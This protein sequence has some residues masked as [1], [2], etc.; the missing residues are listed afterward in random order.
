VGL[1]GTKRTLD[2]SKIQAQ[3]AAIA[4]VRSREPRTDEN[5]F[6]E[7]M[8]AL[9]IAPGG[10]V[11]VGGEPFFPVGLYSS[12]F[13]AKW[14][15]S[16][17][18]IAAAGFNVV[19][20]E[21]DVE[22]LDAAHLHGMKAIVYLGRLLDVSS[23]PERR[24]KSIERI[25]RP[26]A[27]HPALIAFESINEPSWTYAD[28]TANRVD[29][30]GLYEGHRYLKSLAP[31]RAILV[32]H[33]PHQL[34]TTLRHYSRGATAL[35]TAYYPIIPKNLGA[36]YGRDAYGFHG[37]LPNQSPSAVGD[38]TRKTRRIAGN[39]RSVWTTLQGFPWNMP[40][41]A[42]TPVDETTLRFPSRHELR[43]MAYDA[44]VAGANGIL[45]WG[46]HHAQVGWPFW[47]DLASV[48]TELSDRAGVLI[49]P[50][51]PSK[52]RLRYHELGYSDDAAIRYVLKRHAGRAYLLAVNTS[53]YRARVSFERVPGS[54]AS[55]DVLGESRTIIGE[56][57]RFTDDFESLA[58]HVY[59][60]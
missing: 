16:I 29:A 47:T 25:V 13:P 30:D 44:I 51:L 60:W 24:R 1:V 42:D 35:S 17:S 41:G 34:V 5:L 52:I 19:S 59:S 18:D 33:A 12:L 49:S 14:P 22:A 46:A 58:V 32:T 55:V 36:T 2:S 43:F 6:M 3:E 9:H 40:E 4:A 37:D 21:P 50:T 53:L 8:K 26:L 28:Y 23:N 56:D 27:K 39:K 38:Y 31:D 54:G 20:C 48:A 15:H 45:F 57:H 7:G 10:L 11:Q